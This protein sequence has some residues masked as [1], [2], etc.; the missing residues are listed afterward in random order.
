MEGAWW[1]LKIRLES[2]EHD[3]LKRLAERT[4]KDISELVHEILKRFIE[5]SGGRGFPPPALKKQP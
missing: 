2:E 1:E 4:G 5:S 3:K